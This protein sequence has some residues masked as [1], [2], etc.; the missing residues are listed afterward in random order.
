VKNLFAAVGSA[1][2]Y[3][4]ILPNGSRPQQTVP[5]YAAIGMLPLVGLVIGAL[6]GAVGYG[7][8]CVTNALLGYALAYCAM[9]VF[10]GAL[11]LD[12]FL[13][14]C[15]A[16]F[17]S[18]DPQNR[19]K[20]LKD[21]THGTYAVAGMSIL[22]VLWIATLSGFKPQT[23]PLLLAFTG[24]LARTG[25]LLP[26]FFNADT[27]PTPSPAL[28]QSPSK[29]VFFAWLAIVLAGSFFVGRWVWAVIPVILCFNVL[30]ARWIAKQLGGSLVGDSY[31]FLI[32]IS[33][34]FVL[35]LLDSK[36]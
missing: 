3:F 33:E 12:G 10:S 19:L 24:A 17:A 26:M 36:V 4:S 15:D 30:I 16:L 5:G 32:T 20:I 2:G 1:F 23:L 8:S 11:H 35:L 6:A 31:G 22:T 21:P 13:D 9:I 27:R 7:I 18:V 28:A 25:A 34:A 29:F 14:S